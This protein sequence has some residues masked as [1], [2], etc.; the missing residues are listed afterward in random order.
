MPL[1]S[2]AERADRRAAAGYVGG[3]LGL[4]GARPRRHLRLDLRRCASRCPR[5]RRRRRRAKAVSTRAGDG[6]AEDDDDVCG[7]RRR[8]RVV[9]SERAQLGGGQSAAKEARRAR[10]TR[11]CTS[12]TSRAGVTAA[13]TTR[14]VGAC[15]SEMEFEGD[16]KGF[17]GALDPRPQDG[18]LYLLG[19][20]PR[21]TP[22]IL[23][24]RRRN[25]DR[26]P[27]APA[28]PAAAAAARRRH[29]RATGGS[30]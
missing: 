4:R 13:P 15:P 26:P 19:L 25:S 27:A 24:R 10:T 14:S 29:R 6:G 17:E 3:R 8:R 7:R 5:R 28:A 23:A 21:A 18:T 9:G 16:S 30:W 12:S 1:L 20:C 11:W 22:P 2:A